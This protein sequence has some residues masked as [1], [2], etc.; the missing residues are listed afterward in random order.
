MLAVE[1]VRVGPIH[2]NCYLVTFAGQTVIIDPGAEAEK[3]SKKIQDLKLTPTAIVNT[4][5]H[6][7]HVMANNELKREY[8]LKM[9]TPLKDQE[10]LQKEK[11]YY[12]IGELAV[13]Y[14]YNET[15]AELPFQVIPTPGHTAGSSCL[16]LEDNLFSGDTLFADGYLGRTDLWGGDAEAMQVSLRKLLTLPDAVQV[17]PG[18]AKASSIGAERKFYGQK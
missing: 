7:D 5:G 1:R 13:D 2:T 10:L 16:L 4:H 15:L 11:D 12:H 17:W 6:W 14:W 3:I 18:H 9:Y 8:Q